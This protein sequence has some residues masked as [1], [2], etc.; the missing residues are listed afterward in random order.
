MPPK[1]A[2]VAA[3]AGDEDFSEE[4][5]ATDTLSKQLWEA[6]KSQTLDSIGREW[7][8]RRADLKAKSEELKELRT[9][10]KGYGKLLVER[11]IQDGIEILKVDDVTVM[12]SKDIKVEKPT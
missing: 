8:K 10:I 9:G 2:R 12:R 5:T 3:A 6:T 4:D 11:M 1:R 7:L